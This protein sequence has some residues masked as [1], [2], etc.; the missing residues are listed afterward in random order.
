MFG[1][2]A[3]V[4]LDTL[5]ALPEE[6]PEATAESGT[7]M[8]MAEIV[9]AVAMDLEAAGIPAVQCRLAERILKGR[10]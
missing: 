6:V 1:R 10:A 4:A 3:D 5:G 9:R 2:R 8:L 7:S